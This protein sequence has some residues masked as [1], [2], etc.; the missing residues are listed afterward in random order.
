MGLLSLLTGSHLNLEIS[1]ECFPL[2]SELCW[3][4]V[5]ICDHK[6]YSRGSNYQCREQNQ[7]CSTGSRVL[8]RTAAVL[9][10][11]L[12]C[13]VVVSTQ[14]QERQQGLGSVCIYRFVHLCTSFWKWVTTSETKRAKECY[15][16]SFRICL[17]EFLEF[18]TASSPDKKQRSCFP[19]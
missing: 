11:S 9:L 10:W 18:S 4:P 16:L 2:Q 6:T 17:A 15:V 14:Q 13:V 12:A 19:I 8:K 7:Y 5:L 3:L 1:Q